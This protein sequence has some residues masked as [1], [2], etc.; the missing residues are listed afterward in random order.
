[1][2]FIPF[3]HHSEEILEKTRLIR[4]MISHFM[5]EVRSES[6]NPAQEEQGGIPLSG[7]AYTA[8]LRMRRYVLK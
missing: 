7:M 5:K 6:Y 3:I 4:N 8:L 1:M 2:K